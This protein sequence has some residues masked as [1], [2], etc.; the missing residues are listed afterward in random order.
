MH[1]LY[2][3]FL[4]AVFL[5][6]S[7]SLIADPSFDDVGQETTSGTALEIR[8]VQDANPSTESGTPKISLT[9]SYPEISPESLNL[10]P[11]SLS[12]EDLTPLE[13]P[14]NFGSGGVIEKSEAW[15]KIMG[16]FSQLPT[17]ISSSTEV[18]NQILK[19]E[20]FQ[21]LAK[22]LG[23]TIETEKLKLSPL[24]SSLQL[25]SY[26][27]VQSMM[28][29]FKNL[30]GEIR[31]APNSAQP[32]IEETRKNF[33]DSLKAIQ[34]AALEVAQGL[35]DSQGTLDSSLKK[36]Q[37]LELLKTM[38]FDRSD[39]QF[40]LKDWKQDINHPLNPINWKFDTNSALAGQEVELN[41]KI[42]YTRVQFTYLKRA[43][44]AASYPKALGD[45]L[46]KAVV[47]TSS[48]GKKNRILR[49]PPDGYVLK[50]HSLV[51]DGNGKPIGMALVRLKKG[52]TRARA[53]AVV[54]LPKNGEAQLFRPKLPGEIQSVSSS[55]STIARA[56]KKIPDFQFM[57][58]LLL[59]IKKGIES[60]DSGDT[61]AA[62]NLKEKSYTFYQYCHDDR[63]TLLG[64]D[65]K[66]LEDLLKNIVIIESSHARLL[67]QIL[68]GSRSGNS[69]DTAFEVGSSQNALA[70]CASIIAE[71][72]A[73]DEQAK[74][75]VIGKYS[76]DTRTARIGNFFSRGT[77]GKQAVM[78]ANSV[79]SGHYSLI[80]MKARDW[81]ET[82]TVDVFYEGLNPSPKARGEFSL[83]A[84]TENNR[85]TNDYHIYV[86]NPKAQSYPSL[87]KCVSELI[88]FQ[89]DG[90]EGYY[91]KPIGLCMQGHEDAFFKG[92]DGEI[93]HGTVDGI[94]GESKG[95]IHDLS[96]PKPDHG[97][98]VIYQEA[99]GLSWAQ[100]WV[101]YDESTMTAGMRIREV[102]KVD[103]KNYRIILDG[104]GTMEGVFEKVVEALN[105]EFEALNDSSLAS[106]PAIHLFGA[107][108]KSEY[109]TIVKPLNQ[110]Y[111]GKYAKID[112]SGNMRAEF[113][114]FGRGPKSLNQLSSEKPFGPSPIA[115]GFRSLLEAKPDRGGIPSKPWILAVISDFQ[116][117]DK[118]FAYKNWV[119]FFQKNE[120][121]G[122][123][124][125]PLMISK[126]GAL[127]INNEPGSP[128]ENLVEI[129][130]ISANGIIE[131]KISAAKWIT[132]DELMK[133][134][135]NGIYFFKKAKDGNFREALGKF[136]E[137]IRA[138][139]SH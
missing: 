49:N 90:R 61:E 44:T 1:L 13:R 8:N 82:V 48:D 78:G 68:D 54:P 139:V 17:V 94:E 4:S 74:N 138:G 27:L 73:F 111:T 70:I 98:F 10:K 56:G 18:V 72:Y 108:S 19:P 95:S 69:M 92:E 51:R 14:S 110:K 2:P 135:D 42:A 79:M 124:I 86:L 63:E 128:W 58:Q 33:D 71:R 130:L 30:K 104:S 59:E 35:S 99:P 11:V 97:R 136:M 123:R 131:K 46:Q 9:Q 65:Q 129:Q 81:M 26:S 28:K 101:D 116:D 119:S 22:E 62:K 32:L 89:V 52:E 5:L 102:G 80:E 127:G 6:F 23:F 21:K 55:R 87:L 36:E 25:Q 60:L 15:Q 24:Y 113:L 103:K 105:S 76:I 96:F 115:A 91:K 50:V 40:K 75:Q 106:I 64:F 107:V 43:K 126:N 38:N 16:E 118:C 120:V 47:S 100:P 84:N 39:A 122:K 125:A 83:G 37:D 34:I 31:F 45:N 121:N 132:K 134:G 85:N 109:D 29:E 114:A 12:E 53:V 93:L 88:P 66:E 117:S 137:P 112:Q 57:N 41:Q 133:K 3:F 7:I 77:N 20:S 67:D